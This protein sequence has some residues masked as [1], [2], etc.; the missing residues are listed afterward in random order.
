MLK[1]TRHPFLLNLFLLPVYLFAISY[2]L[3][4]LWSAINLRYNSNV[5]EGTILGY[6]TRTSSAKFIWNRKPEHAPIVKF[7]TQKGNIVKV[8]S[9]VY[10]FEK[11]YEVGNTMAVYYSDKDPNGAY[12]EGGFTWSRDIILLL[13]MLVGVY[14]TAP[15]IIERLRR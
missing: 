5:T 12:V 1:Q 8:R 6:K 4:L 2:L 9:R 3:I 7:N 10:E 13:V 15:P 11:E 14:Y